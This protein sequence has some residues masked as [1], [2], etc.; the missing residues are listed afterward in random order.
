MKIINSHVHIGPSTALLMDVK[1]EDV[2]REMTE[3][4]ISGCLVFPFPSWA[5][6]N[7]DVNS[8]IIEVCERERSFYPV[9]YARNDLKPPETDRY[10]AVKWHWV[11]GVSDSAS[12]Y[13]VFDDEMLEDFVDSVDRLGIPVI[14][15]EEF[16]FTKIFAER[17]DRIILIIPHLG[18]LGGSPLK[19]LGEFE[20]YDN[21]YFDTSLSS[22]STL[23]RFVEVIGADR[24]IFGSDLPFSTMSIELEKIMR[25][26]IDKR[27]TEK[28]LHRNIERLCRL[29]SQ[30]HAK[31]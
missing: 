9:F 13:R 20:S 25:L 22:V 8:W 17:F 18:A 15:E 16:E 2:R 19:F 11:K 4:G 29:R 10:V 23:Q 12:N 31:S 3:A 7:P 27:E 26:E 28:I 21:I 24:I 5:V 30:R 6:E 14:F 1:S